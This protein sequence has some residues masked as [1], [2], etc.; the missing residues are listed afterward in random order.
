MSILMNFSIHIHTH[1]Q[2]HIY[3][4]IYVNLIN[5]NTLSIYLNIF[6]LYYNLFAAPDITNIRIII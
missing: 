6:L 1:T 4:Y 5:N 3:I 2:T